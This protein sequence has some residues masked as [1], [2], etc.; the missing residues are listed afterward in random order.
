MAEH[1]FAVWAPRPDLVRLD[2]DGALYPMERGADDWWRATLDVEPGARYGFVL[3]DDPTVL[4]DPRSAR[5]PDGVHARSALWSPAGPRPRTGRADP[6]PARSS[7]S[8]TWEPSRRQELW[9][10]RSS[11]STT[12]CGWAWTSSS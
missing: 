1:Q 7:T 2:V 9:I 3:D 12:W 8:Y 11:G 5:Q 6:L 4:P 10:L